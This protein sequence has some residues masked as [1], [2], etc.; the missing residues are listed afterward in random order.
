MNIKEILIIVAG[1]DGLSELILKLLGII[2]C[3]K[4]LMM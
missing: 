3:V 4:Y 1:L 2:V